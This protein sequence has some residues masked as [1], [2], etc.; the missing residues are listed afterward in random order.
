MDTK[1]AITTYMLTSEK[2]V[3][4]DN[5][6]FV[7]VCLPYMFRV[8]RTDDAKGKMK[9]IMDDV[10]NAKCPGLLLRPEVAQATLLSEVTSSIDATKEDGKGAFLVRAFARLT[11]MS[12]CVTAGTLK[13]GENFAERVMAAAEAKRDHAITT[14]G[15]GNDYVTSTLRNRATVGK[16]DGDPT[17]FK[18]F[19]CSSAL[20]ALHASVE[21]TCDFL[22]QTRGEEEKGLVFSAFSCRGEFAPNAWSLSPT[23]HIPGTVLTGRTLHACVRA[24]LGRVA[25]SHRVREFPIIA[26]TKENDRVLLLLGLN[27]PPQ[28]GIS[29]FTLESLL[30]GL[31]YLQFPDMPVFVRETLPANVIEDE[32]DRLLGEGTTEASVWDEFL[33]HSRDEDNELH[34]LVRFTL[35]LKKL[36]ERAKDK[37]KG[38][39]PARLGG[40][41][42]MGDQH[43]SQL[44][45]NAKT[46]IADGVT[47]G[48]ADRVTCAKQY[49]EGLPASHP[50]R[51]MVSS[52]DGI[53]TKQATRD[54][55]GYDAGPHEARLA[56]AHMGSM[57]REAAALYPR[58]L[59]STR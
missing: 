38:K 33:E 47:S 44:I 46:C 39:A 19:G 42:G 15:Q 50:F 8:A 14:Y 57:T 25:T 4:G 24:V 58:P 27:P 54:I 12:M 35:P 1:R 16:R 48:G 20:H 6:R 30:Q 26:N 21:A 9:G 51:R 22:G 13:D 7:H 28:G 5:P 45:V 41:P 40:R 11:V 56:E 34:V 3:K 49:A 10:I 43:A 52:I 55:L 53:P 59:L 32:L 36:R 2:Y 37:G 23:E 31:K 17:G 29:V 18:E